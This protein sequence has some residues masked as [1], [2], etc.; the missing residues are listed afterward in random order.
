MSTVD[1]DIAEATLDTIPTLAWSLLQTGVD[2]AANPFHT[3]TIAT[4]GQHGPMQR[5]VVLRFVDPSERLLV[6]HTDRRS[7][8]A[9][10]IIDQP[11]MSWH[12]YD[13]KLKLQLRLH[14]RGVLHT[15]DALADACWDRSANR[16]RV[17]YNT[18]T[19]PG[20]PVRKPPLAPGAIASEAEATD[21]R[22]NFAAIACRVKF[23]D[24]LYLSREG[25]RRAVFELSNDGISATWVTP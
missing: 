9:R 20:T 24:W 13:R 7:A 6:C 19:G 1:P 22:N 2:V 12:F 8:K 14:G 16:S 3:P 25:H 18:A 11:S 23:L 10:E 4:V 21:A 5:T 15:D 17:C